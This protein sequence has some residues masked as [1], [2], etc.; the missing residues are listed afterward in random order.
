VAHHFSSIQKTL[1]TL[2]ELLHCHII[3]AMH[4]IVFVLIKAQAN[5]NEAMHIDMANAAVATQKPAANAKQFE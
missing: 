5:R 4:N 3:V 1:E 2:D